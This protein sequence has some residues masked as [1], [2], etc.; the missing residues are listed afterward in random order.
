MRTKT[1]LLTAAL[2]AAGIASSMAQAVYSVNAVGYVNK[3]IP[4]GFSLITN[5][6]KATDNT[7]PGLLPGVPNGTAVFLWNGNAFASTLTY[8]GAPLNRWQ[9][10]ATLLARPVTPGQGFFIKNPT[11]AAFTVTFVG[12]VP[13][14]PDSNVPIPAGLTPLGSAV[15]QDGTLTALQFPAAG[16]DQVF[17]YS[18]ASGAYL[19][20][21]SYIGAPLNRWNPSE[22][23]LSVG[24]AAF[25]R[26]ATAASWNRNF[27]VNG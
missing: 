23:T 14:G 15:P 10:D 3:S 12:E 25:I 24:D 18:N 13:Q 21:F 19:P 11:T 20:T 9:G 1:L 6:L 22:P 26:K 8:I 5:P 16:G 2:A 4:P 27:S 17:I 7:V